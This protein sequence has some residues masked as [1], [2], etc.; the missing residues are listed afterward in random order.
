M[1]IKE[2]FFSFTY[3]ISDNYGLNGR[4]RETS[5]EANIHMSWMWRHGDPTYFFLLLNVFRKF[6]N[7]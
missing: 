1:F 7:I 3:T 2:D 6:Y 4:G 5:I